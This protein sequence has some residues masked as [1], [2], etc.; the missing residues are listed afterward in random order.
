MLGWLA[1]LAVA[2]NNHQAA[3]AYLVELLSWCAFS[4]RVINTVND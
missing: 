1:A 3:E 2:G 4:H